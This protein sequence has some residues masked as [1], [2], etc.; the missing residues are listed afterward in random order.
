LKLRGLS[1]GARYSVMLDGQPAG[2]FT[3]QSLAQEGL[4]VKLDAEWRAAVVEL[5]AR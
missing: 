2:T 3:Q 1:E 5:E 4:P